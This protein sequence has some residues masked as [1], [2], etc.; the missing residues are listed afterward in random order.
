MVQHYPQNALI[1]TEKNSYLPP[2]PPPS[3]ATHYSQQ[4]H[5]T[6][7]HSLSAS[8]SAG[9]SAAAAAAA[10]DF[11]QA[12]VK[13]KTEIDPLS[14]RHN[15]QGPS[16]PT[17]ASSA[18]LHQ[19]LV[20][21]LAGHHPNAI[22][23]PPNDKWSSSSSMS[24]SSSPDVA[25]S[26]RNSEHSTHNGDVTSAP[27]TELWTQQLP[28]NPTG[29][30]PAATAGIAHTAAHISQQA[31]SNQPPPEFWCS[32]A[33]F[34]LDQNVGETF[35]VP[36]AFNSVIIDGYVDPSGGNRFCLGA[37]SNVH[38]SEQSEKARLHIGK[39]NPCNSST[40]GF[41]MGFFF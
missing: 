34:E 31:L 30:A 36:S 17:Q 12:A 41:N 38:R 3:A 9:T 4:P 39:G 26:S 27:G 29:S 2:P 28:N 8:G 22:P 7:P 16:S 20:T 35:K 24:F 6:D 11:N 32:I 25:T 10:G 37:L 40:S 33:Y 1:K 23:V 18:Q 13:I 5:F 21:H 15:G 19:K 14:P